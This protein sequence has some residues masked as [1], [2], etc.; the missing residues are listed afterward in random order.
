MNG[1]DRLNPGGAMTEADMTV[2]GASTEAVRASPPAGVRP[3]SALSISEAELLAQIMLACSRGQSRLWRTNAGIAW[4]GK[5]AEHTPRRLVL[6]DPHPVKLGP[7]GFA[8]LNGFT[9]V[10]ITADMVGSRIAVYSA[11]E[12]KVGRRQATAEQAA[13]IRLVREAGGRAG[14]A[15]SVEEAVGILSGG[16]P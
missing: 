4:A 9:S 2:T 11:V 10:T 5:I 8:D 13:F 12:G 1:S 14:V 3:T 15:R 16:L 7:P 6:I